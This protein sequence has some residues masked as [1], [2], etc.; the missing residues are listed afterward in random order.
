[1][2]CASLNNDN[3]PMN[4]R[5]RALSAG[6]VNSGLISITSNLRNILIETFPQHPHTARV[7]EAAS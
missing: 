6:K 5:G 7:K 1:M 4:R 3:H 2:F